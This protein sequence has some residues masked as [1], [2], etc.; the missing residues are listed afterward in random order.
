VITVAEHRPQLAWRSQGLLGDK[1]SNAL[2]PAGR[3][4]RRPLW[5]LPEPALLPLDQGYPLHQ[6]RLRILEGPE[7]LETGW[8]DEDGIARDYYTAVNPRGMR[9]WVFRNR[10]R[11]RNAGWYLHGFFG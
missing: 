2:V 6:G 4:L 10:N 3:D 7:R 8:W 5:M 9:L 11:R 1:I